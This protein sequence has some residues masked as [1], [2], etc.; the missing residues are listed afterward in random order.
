MVG[1]GRKPLNSTSGTFPAKD[2]T[3][4]YWQ[5]W[6]PDGRRRATVCL[7]HGLGEHVGRYEHVARALTRARISL[8]GCDLRGHGRS[9]G[10]RGHTPSF[11]QILDDIGSLIE[12]AGQGSPLFLYGHSLGGT[13]VVHY[14]L[15]RPASLKGVVA[16][17]PWLRLRN[18]IPAARRMLA[19]VMAGI[20]PGFTQ[21][22]GLNVQGLSRD[23]EVVRKYVQDPLVHD[24]I[25]A[26]LGHSLILAGEAA[27]DRGATFQ[28]PVL[29][30]HGEADPLTDPAATRLL[31]ER[32]ASRDKTLRIWPGLLH[33]I[34]NE[35][36]QSE[37]IDL[38]VD[39][40][41]SRI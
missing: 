30:M 8:L 36:E 32:M 40:F 37:V 21:A 20:Y 14:G 25:S 6:E 38:M 2:G 10:P 22:S 29:L 13:I 39:W 12:R 35:P 18:P 26:M 11:H 34:H 27:L 3:P 15:D 4:L 1:R 19:R 28:L 24:R 9:G 17:G 7:C 33:E 41:A 31:F 5:H 16:T 23:P